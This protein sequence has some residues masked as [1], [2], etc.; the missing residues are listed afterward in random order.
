[1]NKENPN[2]HKA[3]A[4]PSRSFWKLLGFATLPFGIG[5]F[6]V[7]VPISCACGNPALNILGSFAKSQ[8]AYFL[9]HKTLSKSFQDLHIGDVAGLNGIS[10]RYEYSYEFLGDR[11]YMYATPREVATDF[12]RLGLT[13]AKISGV[14][15]AIK[16]DD[17]QENAIS[18]VC[19]AQEGS[20]GKPP[21][22]KFSGSSFTCPDGYQKY[23][24]DKSHGI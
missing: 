2:N 22:P 18:V 10:T 4:L 12:F 16:I 9:E 17:R 3:I 11:A 19:Y 6:F 14:V 20:S 8:Q 15:S 13:K 21:Q 7:Q 5:L 1:M 24:L 23:G